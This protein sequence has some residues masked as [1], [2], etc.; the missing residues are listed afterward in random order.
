MAV[1]SRRAALRNAVWGQLEKQEAE[2]VEL[3]QRLVRIPSVN[4]VHPEDKIAQAI[5][6]ELKSRG[7]SPETPIYEAG[8]P[9]VLATLGQ[10]LVGAR[11]T[12]R[13]ESL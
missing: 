4:G 5:A 13:P 3:C 12:T 2:L 10:S 9:N 1:E 11:A 7:L 6:E 8:R